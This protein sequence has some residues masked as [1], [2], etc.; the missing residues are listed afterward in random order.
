MSKGRFVYVTY[1]TAAP[2][3]V[4]DALISEEATRAYWWHVNSS[5]W[6]KGS[7]WEHQRQDP[8]K[9]VDIEGTVLEIDR[10]RRLVITWSRPSEGSSP[11]RV[12]RVT[13]EIER[14]NDATRLTVAHEDLD[15]EMEKS[16]AGGWPK[17]LANLKSFLETGRTFQVWEPR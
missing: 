17:V 16:V 8:A 14:Y 10:P 11:D 2:E 3:K 9:T 5:D 1:I 12:S 15:P 13:F 4:F 6:K 7:R